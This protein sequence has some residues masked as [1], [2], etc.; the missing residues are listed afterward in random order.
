MAPFKAN[1]QPY[2]VKVRSLTE[3]CDVREMAWL[4]GVYVEDIEGKNDLQFFQELPELRKKQAEIYKDL[5]DP[6]LLQDRLKGILPVLKIGIDEF[7]VNLKERTLESFKD[8]AKDI[9]FGQLDLQIDGE[10]CYYAYWN[11]PERKFERQSTGS[12][13]NTWALLEIPREEDLDPVGVARERGF[14]DTDLLCCHPLQLRMEAKMMPLS[15][16]AAQLLKEQQKAE[17]ERQMKTNPGPRK[18]FRMN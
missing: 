1:V 18:G 2:Q 17:L 5:F 6:K 9:Y 14:A 4:Y 12:N 15:E 16:T 10:Q 8:P 3:M 11:I 7:K 13:M